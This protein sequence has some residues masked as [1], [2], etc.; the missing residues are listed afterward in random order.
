VSREA[1]DVLRRAAAIQAERGHCKRN[2]EDG[3]GHVCLLRAINIAWV[4]SLRV[5]SALDEI[6][7]YLRTA[8]SERTLWP[9]A[10]WNDLP[11]TTGVDVEKF[12]LKAADEIEVM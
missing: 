9:G 6:R 12:L 11:E 10:S 7:D 8:F 2:F 4:D 3:D 1:A 5:G